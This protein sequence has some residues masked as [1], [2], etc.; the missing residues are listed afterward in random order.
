MLDCAMGNV[1][2]RKFF[3]FTV[4]GDIPLGIYLVKVGGYLGLVMWVFFGPFSWDTFPWDSAK[5]V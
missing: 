3:S 5:K 1:A 2:W 4:W